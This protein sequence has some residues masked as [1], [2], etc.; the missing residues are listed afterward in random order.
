[1]FE[2]GCHRYILETNR[3]QE[4]NIHKNL[5]MWQQIYLIYFKTLKEDTPV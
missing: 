1:M 3:K 2:E 4:K 5:I